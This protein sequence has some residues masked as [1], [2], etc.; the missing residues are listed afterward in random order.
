MWKIP[1]AIE[2]VNFP[3]AIRSLFRF[4][5]WKINVSSEIALPKDHETREGEA[6]KQV[7]GFP[8]G[9]DLSTCQLIAELR[10]HKSSPNDDPVSSTQLHPQL[11]YREIIVALELIGDPLSK[12]EN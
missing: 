8:L 6:S 10:A 9:V 5:R 4:P 3:Q 7:I 12:L 1:E 11:P 2:F